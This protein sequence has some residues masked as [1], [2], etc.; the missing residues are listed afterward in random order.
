MKKTIAALSAL[1][2]IG[3]AFAKLPPASEE[4]KAKAEEAK[5]KAAW[6]DKVAAYQLCLVQDR[7]AAHYRKTRGAEPKMPANAPPFQQGA[8]KPPATSA[9]ASAA[10]P[11]CQDPGPYMQAQQA[12]AGLGA[13]DARPVPA[14]GK[15]PVENG[16]K[17][18]K[19]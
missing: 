15:P 17:E 2:V 12:S 6:S 14:A 7:V 1:G 3:A 9:A 19:K 13:A 11:P 4:A 8:D 10:I 16:K 18:E 5:A